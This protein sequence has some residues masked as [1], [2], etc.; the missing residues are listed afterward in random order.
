MRKA[1]KK[2]P[3]KSK[4]RIQPAP[5]PTPPQSVDIALPELWPKIGVPMTVTMLEPLRVDVPP[6]NPVRKRP[7]YLVRVMH[8]AGDGSQKKDLAVVNN[9]ALLLTT[10]YPAPSY[11][12]KT[13]RITREAR[14]AR[15]NAFGFT[16]QEL[17]GYAA[18]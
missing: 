7:E 8:H 2:K 11:V 18:V 4:Q 10:A 15:V 14:H 9:L 17:T 5:A 12:G 6:P 16:V 3:A 1:K 13:F